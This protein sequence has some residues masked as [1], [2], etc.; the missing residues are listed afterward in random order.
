MNTK[1]TLYHA[2]WCG[3]CKNFIPQWEALTK[4]LEKH[5]IAFEDFEDT[6]DGE[7]ISNANIVAFP[8]IRISKNNNEYEYNGDRSVDGIL[9]ELGVQVGGSN[10]KRIMINY[11]KY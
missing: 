1:I 3:H 4:T 11:T 2:N 5:N 8:T 7:V 6:R 9:N 10:S